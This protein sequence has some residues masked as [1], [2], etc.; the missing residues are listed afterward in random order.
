MDLQT[1]YCINCGYYENGVEME[2]CDQGHTHCE[3]CYAKCVKGFIGY[4]LTGLISG[5]EICK[6]CFRK[7]HTEKNDS[8]NLCN[9]EK[10]QKLCSTCYTIICTHNSLSCC[11]GHMYCKRCSKKNV[12]TMKNIEGTTLYDICYFYLS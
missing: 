11:R 1:R 4:D 7:D 8:C 9:I 6:W 10:H 12:F 3:D 5:S 2:Q